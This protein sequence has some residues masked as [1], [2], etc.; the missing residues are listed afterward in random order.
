MNCQTLVTGSTVTLNADKT[1]LT[2]FHTARQRDNVPLVLLTLKVNNA[3]IKQVGHIKFLGVVFGKNLIWKNHIVQNKKS[4]SLG[5]LH[6]VILF[7]L[8][9]YLESEILKKCLFFLYKQLYRLW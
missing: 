3:L 7:Y 9:I 6:R 5:I 2:L 1:K 8:F 4:K